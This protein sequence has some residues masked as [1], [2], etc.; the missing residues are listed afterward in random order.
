[1]IESPSGKVY[2]G[3]SRNIKLRLRDYRLL[4]CKAQGKLYL[5]IKKHGW[6][7]HDVK[8]IQYLPDDI[9]Q[10]DLNALECFCIDQF[11]AV[12]APILNIRDGGA[13]GK[14][15][16]ATIE[17]IRSKL[18][19]RV[20]FISEE[21]KKKISKTQKGRPGRPISEAQKHA[22]S[23]RWKGGKMPESGKAK[24]GFAHEE[25]IMQCNSRGS[26]IQIWRSAKV[27]C[28]TIDGMDRACLSRAIKLGKLYMGYR[29]NKI[30]K[31]DQKDR[32]TI[33]KN[34][35]KGVA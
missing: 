14:L 7:N 25:P 24:I 3:Q 9:G 19:G 27:V 1:M 8:I 11:K 33:Y 34:K 32:R 16:D 13:R 23:L 28:Q 15:S 2:I 30:S 12:D 21:T 5:S 6:G 22:N 29:W 35:L 31:T 20:G 4:R 10:E 18:K 26:K 17:K